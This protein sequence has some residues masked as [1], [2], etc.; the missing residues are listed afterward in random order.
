MTPRGSF[1]AEI[2]GAMPMPPDVRAEVLE[3]LAAHLEDASAEMVARGVPKTDAEAMAIERLGPP[4][5]LGAALTRARRPRSRVLAAAGSGAWAAVVTG[6][7]WTFVAAVA[8]A[9][10]AL[11]VLAPLSGLSQALGLH[12]SFGYAPVW[13]TLLTA[14]DLNVAAILAGGAAVAAASRAGWRTP[15]EMRPSVAIFGGLAV[16]VIVLGLVEQPFN[17]VGV[18]AFLAVPAA[19]AMGAWFGATRPARV[20]WA[21]VVIAVTGVLAFA[22]GAAVHALGGGGNSDCCFSWNDAT[23]GYSLIGPRWYGPGGADRPGFAEGGSYGITSNGAFTGTVE[24]VD[25]ETVAAFRDYRFEAWRAE[26]PSDSWK[27]VAGQRAPYAIVAAQ[28]DG[29]TIAGTLRVDTDPWT[30]W[31]QVVLTGVGRDGTRYVLADASGPLQ[32]GF[33]GSVLAWLTAIVHG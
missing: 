24:A 30:T 26:G 16:A 18:I 7:G 27:L 8:I 14:L 25:A 11:L 33:Q 29:T 21:A 28:V 32:V 4:V 31:G 20:R 23:H 19:F 3:E 5:E 1:L 9:L 22:G 10:A 6:A 2:D 15:T 17:W 12:L 13:N